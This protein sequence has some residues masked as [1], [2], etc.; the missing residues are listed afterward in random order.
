MADTMCNG[1]GRPKNSR[2]S[3]EQIECDC[4]KGFGGIYC[5]YCSNPEYAY[6]N[7]ED[8]GISSSIYDPEVVHEFLGR[9]KYNEHGYSTVAQQYF[10]QDAL[11]PTIF[12]E[13]CGWADFPDDLDR[14]E[15]SREFGAGEFHFADLYVVNHKQDNIIK[16]KP[17]STG[18]FKFLVQ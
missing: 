8:G 4:D 7:C 2:S 14:I 16:F 6:P 10:S 5:D 12:N 13:E 18:T 17:R 15:F 1:H 3:V 11:E 9:R